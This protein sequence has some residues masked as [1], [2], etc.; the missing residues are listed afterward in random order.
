MTKFSIRGGT[1]QQVLNG[2]QN[3][4]QQISFSG[5]SGRIQIGAPS[6]AGYAVAFSAGDDV[7]LPPFQPAT[8]FAD[9]FL[10][11]AS[12][13]Q[14]GGQVFENGGD[15]PLT[16][17]IVSNGS[18][19][20]LSPNTGTTPA[21]GTATVTVANNAATF[22]LAANRVALT[23]GA[24]APVQNSA[25]ADIGTGTVTI[26]A[27]AVSHVRLPATVAGV[28]NGGTVA[29]RNSA[30]ANSH[31]ATAVIASGAMTGVNLAA[32]SAMVDNSGAV[33]VRNSAGADAHSATAVVSAGVLTG[34]NL[35]ATSAIVDNGDT[36][37][38]ARGETV[39]FT[40]AAGVATAMVR[41]NPFWEPFTMTAGVDASGDGYDAAEGLGS[42]TNQPVAGAT[43]DSVFTPEG[44]DLEI[45]LSSATIPLNNITRASQ[46]GIGGT[47]YSPSDVTFSQTASGSTLVIYITAGSFAWTAGQQVPIVIIP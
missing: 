46:I 26:A 27:N 10:V 3:T 4:L 41:S 38:T 1:S 15:L 20:T 23:T 35:A 8:V 37:T 28:S 5:G 34:V 30:G 17:A 33:S 32:T 6:P 29:V 2:S 19:V 25:G 40:V 22:R 7:M 16:D 43:L 21:Q 36:L 39:S 47:T 12:V 9:G 11:N 13:A 44:N 45:R 31:P 24:T 18:T 42:I 14:Y